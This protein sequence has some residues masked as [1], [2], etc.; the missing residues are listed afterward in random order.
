[1]RTAEQVANKVAAQVSSSAGDQD[2][3]GDIVAQSRL[4]SGT[5][6]SAEDDLQRFAAEDLLHLILGVGGPWA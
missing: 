3:H 4:A 5:R 2:A 1:M 6:L